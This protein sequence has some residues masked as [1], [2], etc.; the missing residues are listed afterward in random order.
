MKHF[1]FVLVAGLSLCSLVSTNVQADEW[2]SCATEWGTC[3]VPYATTVR[4]GAHGEY[5]HGTV[6]GRESV[7]CSNKTFGDPLRGYRKSC[8]YLVQ[9]QRA[10]RVWRRCAQEWGDCRVPY[11]TT[12]RYGASGEFTHLSFDDR[13]SI[14]CSNETFGDPIRGHR[15]ACDYL[16]RRGKEKKRRHQH[17]HTRGEAIRGFAKRY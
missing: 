12:V 17:S 16:V 15:K 13:E 2:R 1:E 9:H 7:W 10:R 11:P 6:D 8:E 14:W 3:D 5:V 4:Y